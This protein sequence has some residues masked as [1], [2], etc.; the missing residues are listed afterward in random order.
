VPDNPLPWTVSAFQKNRRATWQAMHGGSRSW[1]LSLAAEL[2]SDSDQPMPDN[3]SSTIPR[4]PA[5]DNGCDTLTS[6]TL[7]VPS[8]RFP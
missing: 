1:R 6:K 2:N 5:I 4:P 7:A 3:A 8:R